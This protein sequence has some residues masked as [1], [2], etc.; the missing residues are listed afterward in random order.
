MR[1]NL[2][3]TQIMYQRKLANEL[4][5]LAAQFRTVTITGP[6]QAGKT[7]LCR[8]TFP[9]YQYISLENPDT[10]A[11]AI[12]D[13]KGFLNIYR[14]RVILDE[15]QR[16]PHLLS[17]IQGI[18]DEDR[19]S[20]Q[21]I[22]TG[23]HQLALNEAVTQS[24]AGRTALLTLLPLS[25]EEFANNEHSMALTDA[26]SCMLNGFMPG[27][28]I[29]K[30][31]STRFYR[32]YFETYIERDVRQLINLKNFVKFENF[33]RLCAGRIGQLMNQAS[34]AS[35]VGVSSNTIA[36]WL[37]VLEASFVTIRLQPYYE[38]FGK[39]IIKSSKLYFVDV[40]LA[41]WLLGIETVEQMQRDPLRGSL[42]ENMVIIE[43]LKNRLNRGEE[44]GLFFFRDS[45]GHEVDLLIRQGRKLIPCEIKS[46][47]TWHKSFYRGLTYFNNLVGKHAEPG[48][49]VYGGE[50]TYLSDKYRFLP[51]NQVAEI[52]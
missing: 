40:G 50:Q 42:F 21:F 17:Y 28:H 46:S 4:K 26:N 14:H 38:N 23:S 8:M 45:H 27:K 41:A 51:F 49:V 18:V 7:T 9:D 39:R 37:S 31:D 1:L 11:L 33:V 43:A 30:M 3:I 15:I 24:L 25:F 35:D 6:R 20:G 16:A 52:V 48:I 36:E 12:E 29:Q 22:L 47:Q 34:L 5:L 19:Q 13:P 2:I 44:S 32:A 10:R